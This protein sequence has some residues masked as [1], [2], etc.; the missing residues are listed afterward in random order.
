MAAL[1]DGVRAD[2]VLHFWRMGQTLTIRLT[3]EQAKWLKDVAARAGVPQSHVVRE[4]LDRA[5]AGSERRFMA[6]AG[7]VKGPPDLSARKGFSRP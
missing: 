1:A 2:A 7:S 5:M 4:Q 3:P 6:L